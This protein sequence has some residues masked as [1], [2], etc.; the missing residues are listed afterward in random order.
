MSRSKAE[1]THVNPGTLVSYPL[2]RLTRPPRVQGTNFCDF[3]VCERQN[4]YRLGDRRS[5]EPGE[6]LRVSTLDAL[7]MRDKTHP[8]MGDEELSLLLGFSGIS[9][10]FMCF[11]RPE[12]ECKK[13]QEL[14]KLRN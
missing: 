11:L 2:L 12:E 4:F 13:R 1:T 7:E 6:I 5:L 14:Y 10:E 8:D 3:G 9:G